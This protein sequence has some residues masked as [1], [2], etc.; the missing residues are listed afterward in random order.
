MEKSDLNFSNKKQDK[1][2]GRTLQ[3]IFQFNLVIFTLLVL[4]GCN[5]PAQQ[6]NGPTND[7][8]GSMVAVTL[9]AM[10]STG[11]I[12]STQVFTQSE[13]LNPMGTIAI[14]SS[15]TPTLTP[16]SNTGKVIGLV[17]F[18]EIA[19]TNLV[20]YF[21]NTA[22]NKVVELPVTVS[23]YQAAYSQELNPGTYIAYA[24]NTDFSIGG[25]YSACG[26]DSKCS[27][28]S[29]KPFVVTA[30]QTLA[31]IDVCD[32]S[33]GP[34][35][36]PYPPGFE[37][38]SKFG[39]IAGN[40]YGYPYGGLPQL[41]VVAFNKSTGYWYWVGTAVGQSYF[42]MLDIPAGTYQVVAYDASGHAGGSSS[43]IIVVGGQTINIDI[44]SWSGTY[45]ANPLK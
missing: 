31:K 9:T 30:G 18:T 12:N 21:Q 37:A 33:H 43:N 45:P 42:T 29:P 40:I 2:T 38:A 4:A 16:N 34:F 25:T 27:D 39:T 20:V 19:S 28:A 44:N 13:T 17:Y 15:E 41:T 1:E 14:M 7:P 23:N 26:L 36:V 5:L 3:R 10:S 32:W 22:D 8:V 24:W 35:D 11:N 6:L